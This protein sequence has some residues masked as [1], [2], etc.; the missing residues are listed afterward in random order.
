MY[1]QQ[2][3]RQ[4]LL[5]SSRT[6]ASAALPLSTVKGASYIPQRS[7]RTIVLFSEKLKS[8]RSILSSQSNYYSAVS[9]FEAFEPHSFNWGSC[10]TT[11]AKLLPLTAGERHLFVIFQ[12]AFVAKRKDV[13]IF[14]VRSVQFSPLYPPDFTPYFGRWDIWFGSR[15]ATRGNSRGKFQVFVS[16]RKGCCEGRLS[17]RRTKTRNF[18]FGLQASCS[19]QGVVCAFVEV[20]AVVIFVMSASDQSAEEDKDKHWNASMLF[21]HPMYQPSWTNCILLKPLNTSSRFWNILLNQESWLN[22]LISIIRS[23]YTG[24]WS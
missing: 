10:Q 24:Q 4:D 5:K 2:I 18:L 17:W 14:K 19:K 21:T 13:R 3:K 11:A 6:P 9:S 22:H 12:Q 20:V 15:G 23:T 16:P 1:W 8:S 7:F